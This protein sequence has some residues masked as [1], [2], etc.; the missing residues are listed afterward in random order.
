M[1][2]APA[3]PDTIRQA[4]RRRAPILLVL[5]ATLVVSLFLIWLSN[6]PEISTWW[7]SISFICL[8]F[9]ASI[10]MFLTTRRCSG[11][12][13]KAWF[14]FGLG[15][16]FFA[17]AEAHWIFREFVYNDP[18]PSPSLGDIGYYGFP[19]CFVL[20]IWYYHIRAQPVGVPLSQIGNLGII[21][22]ALMLAYLFQYYELVKVA[23]DLPEA[24]TAIA[25][26]IFDIS[27]FLFALVVLSLHVWGRKRIS[28]VLIVCA[29]AVLATTDFFYAFALLH[30]NYVSTGWT[31]ALYPI[32][33]VTLIMAACEQDLQPDGEETLSHDPAFT[34]PSAQ[35]ETL[36][37]PWQ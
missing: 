5:L 19:I 20:G 11:D 12:E 21:V 23:P 14:C 7:S 37:A 25:Y 16:L 27:S 3:T 17:C 33:F 36:V 24:L 32:V 31:G 13:R 28:L 18:T 22:S 10:K 9:A 29:L 34:D 8:P 35:W 1:L 15:C 30:Q 4:L 26:G 2:S 6:R